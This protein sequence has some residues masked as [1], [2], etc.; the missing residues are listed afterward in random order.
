MENNDYVALQEKLFV[1]GKEFY[2]KN[3]GNGVILSGV[4]ETVKKLNPDASKRLAR[5]IASQ[6]R[7]LSF[8][9]DFLQRIIINRVLLTHVLKLR[10][11]M[12]VNLSAFIV[13]LSYN[14]SIN[15][16]KKVVLEHVLPTLV[17]NDYI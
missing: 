12:D 9:S 15:E 4:L 5:T 10:S 14:S 7:G 17:K 3:N 8:K 13:L 6:D 1:K 16:W 2:D 11:S